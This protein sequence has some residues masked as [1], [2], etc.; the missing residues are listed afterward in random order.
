MKFF[1]ISRMTKFRGHYLSEKLAVSYY[2]RNIYISDLTLIQENINLRYDLKCHQNRTPLC[3][4]NNYSR[5]SSICALADHNEHILCI[6][7][8]DYSF[9]PETRFP[10]F[11]GLR[12]LGMTTLSFTSLFYFLN[13]LF[14]WVAFS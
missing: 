4:A 6:I 12:C 9:L 3:L 2:L 7:D 5:L 8:K 11:I 1:S 10:G 13:I 14:D